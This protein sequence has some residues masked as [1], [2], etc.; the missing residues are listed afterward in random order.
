VAATAKRDFRPAGEPEGFS[1][2]IDDLE[3][4]FDP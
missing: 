3:V 2:G 1:S 4:T